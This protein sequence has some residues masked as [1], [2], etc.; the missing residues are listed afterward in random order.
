MASPQLT[1]IGRVIQE[2]NRKNLRSQA[3]SVVTPKT[4]IRSIEKLLLSFILLV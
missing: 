1:A 3:I 4:I 2:K